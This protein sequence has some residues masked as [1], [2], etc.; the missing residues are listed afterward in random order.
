MVHFNRSHVR[1][2]YR[3]GG[4]VLRLILCVLILRPA[5]VMAQGLIQ[6]GSV[7]NV[8]AQEPAQAAQAA[9]AVQLPATVPSIAPKVEAI[10]SR[11]SQ[12]I[13]GGKGADAVA[14][15]KQ[16][17]DFTVSSGDW[18]D[19]GVMLGAGETAE[20]T[21]S[22]SIELQDGRRTT[23][24]G[25]DR[26]WK[27]LMR[28]FPSNQ[29]KVGSLIGRVSDTGA[30][31]PFSIG[32]SGQVAMP[33]TGK[34]YLRANVSNDLTYTGEYKVKVKFVKAQTFNTNVL[35]SPASTK[36]INALLTPDIFADIPRRVSDSTTAEANP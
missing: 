16:S 1:A 34:L 25:L 3:F 15:H 10:M 26:G 8:E 27:D 35:A 23:A 5:S 29:A 32:A 36:P 33:T 30:S 9:A 20:F 24:D 19:T 28:Q 12:R 4:A 14:G 13:S 22:G 6:S 7:Q 17:Y 18:L 2:M 31:V 11:R 21:V